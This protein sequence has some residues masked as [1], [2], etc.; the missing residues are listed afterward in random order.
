L[1]AGDRNGGPQRLALRLA[2]SLVARQRFD[3]EDVLGRCLAWWRAGAFDTGP[4]AASVFRL[5]E[6]GMAPEQAVRM[7]D[8]RAAGRTAGVGPAH[9]IAPLG[10]LTAVPTP[11]VLAVARRESRLTHAHPLAGWVSGATALL[12]RR[13]VEGADLEAAPRAAAADLE[14]AALNEGD[15]QAEQVVEILWAGAGGALSVERARP[16][17]YAPETL[18]AALAFLA[19]YESFEQALERSL[20]FAGGAN[21]A[22]VL[23]GTLAG[24]R[25][26]SRAIPQNRLAHEPQT[27]RAFR[28]LMRPMGSAPD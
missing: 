20:R 25:E 23:V 27:V 28:A 1:V 13:L 7:V 14:R 3:V 15:G 6:Q 11:Q 21:D 18:V 2:Q 24:A 5:I 22:P 19:R 10:A 8:E 16:C 12:V 4:T 17:G 26:G 9:R